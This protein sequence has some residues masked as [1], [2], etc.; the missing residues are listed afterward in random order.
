[1]TSSCRSCGAAIEWAVTGKGR[2]MPLDLISDP[3]G[4]LVV[5]AGRVEFAEHAPAD[6]PTDLPRRTTHFARCPNAKQHRRA[7]S[8]TGRAET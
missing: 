5:H 7:P 1:M 8:P 6:W 4:L 2:R 3:G